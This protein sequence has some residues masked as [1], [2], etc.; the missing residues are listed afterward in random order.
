MD[1]REGVSVAAILLAAG[2]A[3]RMGQNGPHKLLAEFDSV[4]LVR[5]SAMVLLASNAT[6]VVA[7]TGHRQGD[8]EQALVGLDIVTL[9]NRSYGTGMASSLACGV[10]HPQ[11][12]ECDGVLVMLADMPG[13]LTEH[14][15]CIVQ[16]FQKSGGEAIVRASFGDTPGHPVLF[17]RLLYGHL[18]R[19][20]GDV[21]AREVIGD[22]ELPIVMIDI[23]RAALLDVDTPTAIIENGGVL[24]D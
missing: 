13:I 19:L 15:D 11:I 16:A 7:V 5:R 21:G 12:S 14:I 4:P 17:P 6:P 20:E 18:M 22:S 9:F 8:V 10:S 1:H 2:R 3:R 23:G 24:R